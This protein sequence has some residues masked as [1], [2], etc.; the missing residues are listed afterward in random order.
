MNETPCGGEHSPG[1]TTVAS[2]AP[3]LSAKRTQSRPQT[4]SPPEETSSAHPLVQGLRSRLGGG[5]PKPR[6]SKER[7]GRDDRAVRESR[8][9]GIKNS[10]AVGA[11][12]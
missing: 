8:G 4:A 10:M 9:Q 2:V 3:D 12:A 1:A 6:P 7:M 5:S 11:S